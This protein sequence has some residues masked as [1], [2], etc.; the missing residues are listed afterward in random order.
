MNRTFRIAASA[1]AVAGLA[2]C[3]GPDVEPV[4]AADVAAEIADMYE[5]EI[6]ARPDVTCPGDLEARVGVELVC[7]FT[8]GTPAQVF[9]VT[10]TVSSV[11]SDGTVVF[12]FVETPREDEE[13]ATETASP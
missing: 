12:D 10:A 5:E 7:E 11:S 4:P 8:A 9:E 6:G 13:T 1:L 3:A 2:A